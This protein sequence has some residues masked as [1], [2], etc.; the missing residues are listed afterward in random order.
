MDLQLSC[1]CFLN[2][3]YDFLLFSIFFPSFQPWRPKNL[4]FFPGRTLSQL[5]PENYHSI[6]QKS[7][8]A[9]LKPHQVLKVM[10]MVKTEEFLVK[11]EMFSCVS[12][13]FHKLQ[14]SHSH[15]PSR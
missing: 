7:K 13:I 14:R 9:W 11:Y 4:D 15:V 6:S 5:V 12:L 10:R 1:N 8:W 2:D 3:K